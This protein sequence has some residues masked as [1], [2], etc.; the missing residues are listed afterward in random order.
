MCK[1]HNKYKNTAPADSVYIG[2][3]SPWG[4][5][6]PVAPH[7]RDICINMFIAEKSKDP[8]FIAR[9][10]RELKGKDLV[11]FCKPQAC[12]GDW[13]LKIANEPAVPAVPKM[14][15]TVIGDE[16]APK[17]IL[18]AATDV[19]AQAMSRGHIV[20]SG[21]AKGM[22]STVTWAFNRNVA[23]GISQQH[24]EVY[25]PWNGF[26]ADSQPQGLKYI[27]SGL[28]PAGASLAEKVHPAWGKCSKGARK[29]L[30]RDTH[31]ALGRDLK[32][33]SDLIL[34]WCRETAQGAPTGGTAMAVNIG[35]ANNIPCIN[36]LHSNWKQRLITVVTEFNARA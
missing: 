5:P 15:I 27:V 13:L 34:Y 23:N 1:V 25:I 14:L 4:N 26:N 8:A 3:G 9:V 29:L 18:D 6:Y 10:K 24:P 16:Q 31:Q 35:I 7:G 19:V 36:M 22:D 17:D 11:C 30:T 20:R 28:D 33:P 2:R 21:A 12:H 32:S